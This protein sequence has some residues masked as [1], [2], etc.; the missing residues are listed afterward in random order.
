MFLSIFPTK[1]PG[2]AGDFLR[3]VFFLPLHVD[4]RFEHFVGDRDDLR[5]A[6][7]SALRDDHVRE[8][9]N[10]CSICENICRMI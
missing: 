4:Q 9:V 3:S 6:L 1:I 2:G 7:E 8:L 10:A 5:V